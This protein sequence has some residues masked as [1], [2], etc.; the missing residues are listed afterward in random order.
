MERRIRITLCAL[1]D[2]GILDPDNEI[3]IYC[4]HQT[5]HKRINTRLLEFTRSWNNHPLSTEGNLTPLQLF[6]SLPDDS[7]SGN[8]SGSTYTD[9]NISQDLPIIRDQVNVPISSFIPCLTL[10]A[11]VQ[12]TLILHSHLDD[13][14]LYK[15]IAELVGTHI[16]N[17]HNDTCVFAS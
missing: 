8:D 17:M 10:N 6:H 11:Q 5:L 12:T 16:S 3:D 4:L 13:S 1:E 14:P 9:P 2:E 15:L 7:T